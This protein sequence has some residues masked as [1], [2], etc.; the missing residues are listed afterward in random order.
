MSALALSLAGTKVT[1]EWR[2]A[3]PTDRLLKWQFLVS[4]K[5]QLGHVLFH[6][7]LACER[8]CAVFVG[9]WLV[10]GRT[11]PCKR[12][13]FGQLGTSEGKL[14]RGDTQKPTDSETPLFGSLH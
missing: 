12:H 2:I 10:R 4:L 11:M 3:S 7:M 1:E 6:C 8:A 9:G 5:T 14:R 13:D